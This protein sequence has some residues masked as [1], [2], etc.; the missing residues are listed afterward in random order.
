MW[1]TLYPFYGTREER[2]RCKK[3]EYSCRPPSTLK[4][5]LV[6]KLT[7][8]PYCNMLSYLSSTQWNVEVILEGDKKKTIPKVRR[9]EIPQ[10]THQFCT[11][12]F[13]TATNAS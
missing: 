5:P 2:H 10:F 3:Q 8:T 13:W 1:I 6:Q 7:K 9:R 12:I 11:I 4:L